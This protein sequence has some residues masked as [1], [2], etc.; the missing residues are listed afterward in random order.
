MLKEGLKS[1]TVEGGC[2]EAPLAMIHLSMM[3][4]NAKAFCVD[5]CVDAFG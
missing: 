3:T 2:L 4:Q 1:I 5:F